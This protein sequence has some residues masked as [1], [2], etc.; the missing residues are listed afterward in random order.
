MVLLIDMQMNARLKV[1]NLMNR[2][3]SM[4]TMMSLKIFQVI[5]KLMKVKIIIKIDNLNIMIV[6]CVIFKDFQKIKL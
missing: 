5:M 2:T 1:Q 4:K 6:K 3:L